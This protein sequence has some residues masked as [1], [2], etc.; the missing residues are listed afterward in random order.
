MVVA[1]GSGR[2]KV[3]GGW[4]GGWGKEGGKGLGQRRRGAENRTRREREKKKKSAIEDRW[5]EIVRD[6][7]T[8]RQRQKK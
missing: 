8:P 2:W 5:R 7:Y 3:E 1:A 4:F 6:S